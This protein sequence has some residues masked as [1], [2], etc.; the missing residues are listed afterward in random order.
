ML[1]ST[2]LPGKRA[3]QTSSTGTIKRQA[4]FE[5]NLRLSISPVY[6]PEGKLLNRSA[7]NHNIEIR[8]EGRDSTD[9][10]DSQN[11]ES[12]STLPMV[13]SSGFADGSGSELL[14]ASSESERPLYNSKD[15][16]ILAS[17]SEPPSTEQVFFAASLKPEQAQSGDT[18]LLQ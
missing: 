4:A 8:G 5:R 13:Y 12:R 6:S 14:E 3:R 7:K 18:V 10:T 2:R 15:S 17:S 16:E 1:I 9:S 11:S